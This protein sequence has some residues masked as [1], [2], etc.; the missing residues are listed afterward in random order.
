MPGAHACLALAIALAGWLNALQLWWYLRRARVYTVQPGWPRFLRQLLLAGLGM[1]V[2]V[3][4]L[5]WIWQD[6]TTWA[7][8]Q[9]AWR[10]ALLVGAGA[11]VYGALL[12]LQGI[13][14]RDLRH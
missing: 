4:T 1:T 12:W 10:L 2:V 5:L 14:M 7:W 8:W 6:W 3:L 13:R 9:R 11:A